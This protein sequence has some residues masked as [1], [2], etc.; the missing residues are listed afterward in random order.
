MFALALARCATADTYDVDSDNS[1]LS[2][3]ILDH[4]T[5]NQLTSAQVDGS[6]LTSLG[7]SFDVT[8]GS[9]TITFNS[10]D[11]ITF[12]NQSTDMQ[13]AIGGGSPSAGS[14][15]NPYPADPGS[16]AANYGLYFTVPNDFDNPDAGL[17]LAGVAA[18]RGA[19]ADITSS[20]ISLS[21]GL[22]DASQL[23][24]SLPS[25]HTALDFNVNL[26]DGTPLVNG[27]SFVVGSGANSETFGEVG[28]L[29]GTPF[30]G[31]YV[32]LDIHSTSG[33]LDLDVVL[34]GQIVGYVE[35]G[36]GAMATPVPEP[37]ALVLAVVAVVGLLPVLRRRTSG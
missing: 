3:A 28:T 14:G 17:A 12:G 35:A 32:D 29:F 25:G 23:T 8:F 6:D 27:T 20:A 9:G 37:S 2:I 30:V 34:Q 4:S 26:G 19:L 22:F 36:G 13:P 7:G 10:S 11:N 5:Q 16:G 33:G 24:M 15:D 18:I 31:F 1:Y 21:D